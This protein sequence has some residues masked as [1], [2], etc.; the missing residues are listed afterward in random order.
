MIFYDSKIDISYK[1]II[2]LG[3][4][5]NYH[6]PIAALEK[7]WSNRAFKYGILWYSNVEIA[8]CVSLRYTSL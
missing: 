5:S 6:I 7:C 8:N 3:Q 4:K 1:L 2:T